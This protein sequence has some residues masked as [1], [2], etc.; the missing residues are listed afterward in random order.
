MSAHEQRSLSTET[1]PDGHGRLPWTT[2]YQG[3][4]AAGA[5]SSCSTWA[6]GQDTPNRVETS[7]TISVAIIYEGSSMSSRNPRDSRNIGAPQC[8]SITHTPSVDDCVRVW[9]GDKGRRNAAYLRV[10][11]WS[12]SVQPSGPPRVLLTICGA[13]SNVKLR[14]GQHRAD[15]PFHGGGFV[16]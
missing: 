5:T 14:T 6:H 9:W 12:Y 11:H 8:E 1:P 13:M 4:D 15:D 2:M 16:G 10:K 7:T 3:A